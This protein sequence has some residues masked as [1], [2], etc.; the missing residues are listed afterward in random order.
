MGYTIYKG[1]KDYSKLKEYFE[2]LL[3][4]YNKDHEVVE[5]I[6]YYID[7]PKKAFLEIKKT[8]QSIWAN[9]DKEF[10]KKVNKKLIENKYEY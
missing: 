6:K 10:L 9:F 2:L 4:I 7:T 8:H 1:V 3:N 5:M